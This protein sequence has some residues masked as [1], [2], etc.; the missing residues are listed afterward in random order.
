MRDDINV[1]AAILN[2]RE[3]SENLK[4]AD[5]KTSLFLLQLA[6]AIADDHAVGEARVEEAT[7]LLAEI[8]S[9]AEKAEDGK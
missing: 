3:A 4:A 8:G 7:G 5:P 9:G 2:I 6:K 1:V